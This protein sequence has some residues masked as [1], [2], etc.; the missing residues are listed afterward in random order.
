MTVEEL[1]EQLSQTADCFYQDRNEE[2]M[3]AFMTLAGPIGQQREWQ[4]YINP[5][6][7][8]LEQGDYIWA[9]DILQHDMAES[10]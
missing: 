7:D 8:A 5:L 4:E 3:K 2:G 1:R 10:I 6:F 9:A